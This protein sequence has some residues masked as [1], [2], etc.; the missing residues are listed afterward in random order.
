MYVACT[1]ARDRLVLFVPESI[2]V[3][4]LG[5]HEPVRPSPFVLELPQDS[6]R[7]LREG[8]G[9]RI[10]PVRPAGEPA[11]RPSFGGPDPAPSPGAAARPMK[12]GFCSHKIYGRGKIIEHIPPDKYRVNFQHFGLKVIVGQYL[13][14][15]EA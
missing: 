10:S 4:H 6:C 12:L 2:Y 9:G 13:E 14:M 1:R 3:R 8:F 15:E 7:E 11:S 5:A